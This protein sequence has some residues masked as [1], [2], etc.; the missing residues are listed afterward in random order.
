MGEIT[1]LLLDARAGKPGAQEA[2]YARIYNELHKLARAQL[3]QHQ[4]LTLLDAQAL[5]HETYLRLVKSEELP[6]AN[7]HLFYGYAAGVM[8]H[9]IVDYVRRRRA[10]KRGSGIAPVTLTTRDRSREMRNPD[11]EKLDDALHDLERVDPRA[12]Q[13]VEMR[14]FGGMTLEQIADALDTS[15]ATVKREWTKARVFLLRVM[16]G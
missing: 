1:A 13:I 8:R 9:V 16:Q 6:T 3:S 4:T 14:Y 2:L 12:R 10:Q 5:L 7:R 15:L 11:L